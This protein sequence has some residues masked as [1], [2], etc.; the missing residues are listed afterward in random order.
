MNGWLKYAGVEDPCTIFL[1]GQRGSVSKN[2]EKRHV[3][4]RKNNE[5]WK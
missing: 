4:R 1:L 5:K 2:V 3:K